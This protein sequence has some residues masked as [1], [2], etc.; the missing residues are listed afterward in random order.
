[1][2]SLR[3]LIVSV[4]VAGFTSCDRQPEDKNAETMWRGR[5]TVWCDEAVAPLLRSQIEGFARKYPDAH[6]DVRSATGRE[7]MEALLSRKARIALLARGYLRDEDSL[8]KVYTLEPHRTLHIATD[9]L[10]FFAPKDFPSDTLSVEALNEYFSAGIPLDA[11]V[12]GVRKGTS[13]VCPG[14]LSSVVGNVVLQCNGGRAFSAKARVSYVGTMDSVKRLVRS[15]ENV[16]GVGFLSEMIKDTVSFKLLGIKYTDK[17]MNRRSMTVEQ[18]AVYRE[19]YPYPVKI[20]AYLLENL[21]NLP[22]GLASYL[23]FETDPQK[24]FLNQGI[25]PAYARIQLT[26][27]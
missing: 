26:E 12:R 11:R 23:A 6:I 27:E 19:M 7:V 14:A 4:F 18:S 24:Y 15:Q 13:F 10:V 16:I 22:M 17:D 2:K 5:L 25:V 3:I 9:A 21:R 20:E 1:M 8:M